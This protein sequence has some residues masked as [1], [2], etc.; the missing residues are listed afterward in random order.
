[1]AK[2]ENSASKERWKIEFKDSRGAFR[3]QMAEAKKAL[4][5]DN[6]KEMEKGGGL[7]KLYCEQSDSG[8]TQLCL[9]IPARY[10]ELFEAIASGGRKPS[11][12]LD[13][14]PETDLAKRALLG[15]FELLI[16]HFERG[17]KLT[18]KERRILAK[19]ARGKLPRT[20]RPPET[21]TELRNRDMVRFVKILR[22][23]GGKRVVDVA[24]KKFGVDRSYFSKLEKKYPRAAVA[25]Y[26]LG[27]LLTLF[28]ADAKTA[29]RARLA[30]AGVNEDDIREAAGRKQARK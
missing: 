30:S 20:G 24:A 19:I 3:K 22:A 17:G 23:Y 5:L 14:P 8:K 11:Y 15:E 16:S 28:G 6:K 9:E 2:K 12:R 25:D 18:D 26:L 29:W 27:S 10:I 7:I 1:M 4:P 21:K 13:S